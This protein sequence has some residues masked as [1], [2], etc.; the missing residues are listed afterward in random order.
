MADTNVDYQN[1]LERANKLN[2]QLNQMFEANKAKYTTA[3][4]QTANLNKQSQAAYQEQKIANQEA[5]NQFA[6][7]Q[8]ANQLSALDAIRRSNAS[9]IANGANAGLSAANQL[10]SI[11]GLQE[12]TSE[13]ATNIANQAIENA[14]AYNTQLNENA[15]KGQ[16]AANQLNA[17]L[18]TNAAELAKSLATNAETIQKIISDERN[19]QSQETIEKQKNEIEQQKLDL[20][21]IADALNNL[22]EEQAKAKKQAEVEKAQADAKK[23]AEEAEAARKANKDDGG[24]L[25]PGTLIT[26]ADGTLRAIEDLKVGDELLVW[27]FY[28]GKLDTMPILVFDADKPQEKVIYTLRFSDGTTVPV[29]DEHGFYDATLKQYVYMRSANEAL[30]FI[31]HTFLKLNT[32]NKHEKVK[33]VEVII[34]NKLTTFYDLSTARHLCFYA[35]GILNIA[36]NTSAFVNNFK[37]SKFK[38]K[39]NKFDICRKIKKYGIFIPEDFAELLP[40]EVFYAFQSEFLKIKIEEGKTSMDEIKKLISRYAQ[41]LK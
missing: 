16:E 9:A 31:G 29:I 33:L 20:Q 27:D 1:Q 41:Y 25:A 5:Q 28:K 39:Y 3:E 6:Q 22:T 35:N 23:A 14:A 36:G 17:T 34:E 13:E 10:S 4:E 40:K 37:V 7:N 18:D 24:C 15:V 19:R 26:L 32:K 38:L 21:K 30:E 11:L 12:E 8:S 2:D